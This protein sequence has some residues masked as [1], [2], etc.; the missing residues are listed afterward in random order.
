MRLDVFYYALVYVLMLTSL[1]CSDTIFILGILGLCHVT[2]GGFSTLLWAMAV[3]LFVLNVLIT[4]SV[5]KNEFNGESALLILLMLFTY[6]K[7][8]VAVVIKAV[9]L[10]IQDAV[11]DKEVVWDKTERFEESQPQDRKKKGKKA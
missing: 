11:F 4:L 6:S 2:L 10:S 7:M 3:L 8:W 1:I 9:W 5:E